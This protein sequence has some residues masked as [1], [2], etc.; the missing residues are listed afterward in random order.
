MILFQCFNINVEHQLI[1]K[2]FFFVE[3]AMKCNPTVI[4]D[5]HKKYIQ[6]I[7]RLGHIIL[8]RFFEPWYHL[9]FIFYNFSK[10]GREEIRLLEYI[11]KFTYRI[12]Q[13][14]QQNFK[15]PQASSTETKNKKKLSLMDLLLNTNIINGS[16]DVTGIRD[17]INTF[18]FA[19]SH[20]LLYK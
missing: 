8:D 13:N 19:V 10:S 9:H 7:D 3:A 1:Q 12:I 18:L 4:E 14:G 2:P 5:L 16:I 15:I 17:E 20:C 11:N 6:A